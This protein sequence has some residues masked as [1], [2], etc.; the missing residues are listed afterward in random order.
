MVG[1]A[2]SVIA[3]FAAMLALAGCA[4]SGG[5]TATTVAQ[6]QTTLPHVN[7]QSVAAPVMEKFRP[8]MAAYLTE[9]QKDNDYG[10][11][12]VPPA[13]AFNQ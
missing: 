2:P 3:A 10:N 7:E 13:T 4:P 9:I 8:E 5:S 11:W 1:N 12:R 6:S